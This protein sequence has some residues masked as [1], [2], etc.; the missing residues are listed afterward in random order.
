MIHYV[1]E[2]TVAVV[3][4]NSGENRLNQKF[5]EAFLDVL[6][7]IESDT[8]AG[9][10]VVRSA[11]DKIW[12]NGADLDWLLPAVQREGTQVAEEFLKTCMTCFR[13]ILT[14]PMITV[15]AINGHVFAGG[16]IMACAFDFRF[17][18]S[19]RGYFCLPAIDLKLPLL[20]GMD[21]LI[22]KALPMNSFE[23]QFTGMRLTA[24]A[25]RDEHIVHKTCHNDVLMEEAMTFAKSMNK[26]RATLHAM[27]SM[28]FS[29]ILRIM[30]KED[31]LHIEKQAAML[32]N[33]A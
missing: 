2:D 13:R 26:D 28:A 8:Q 10:L 24:K 25:C 23:M 5:L 32:A 16:A 29:D 30:D 18:R 3:T 1:L 27:K 20:P 11:H 12:S 21:A 9:A 31:P 15:A 14:Y 17:M 7:S 19:D 33:R 6:D 22:R 4:M